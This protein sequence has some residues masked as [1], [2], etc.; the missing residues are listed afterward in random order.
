MDTELLKPKISS[1]TPPKNSY[2]DMN[3]VGVVILGGGQGTRL[4]PLTDSRCKPAI[5]FAGKYRLIDIAISNAIHSAC[6]KIYV[7]TQFLSTSLHK[8]ICR[9]YTGNNIFNDSYVDIL[10][11]EQRPTNHTWYAGTADAVRLNMD[12]LT[13][14]S[15]DYYLILS[16]DQIYSM[17]FTPLVAFAHKTDAD[18]VV[19]SLLVNEEDA[20]RMG[21][22]KINPQ[23]QIQQFVEKPQQKEILDTLKINSTQRKHLSPHSS[24]KTPFLGSMGIYLF[25]R[26]ALIK[27]LE[28][29]SREDFGKHLIPVQIAKGN[30]YAYIHNGF[31]EDIG[32][33]RSFYEANIALTYPEPVF[34]YYNENSPLICAPT[35]LP[36]SRINNT[37]VKHSIICD[38][39]D[40]EAKEITHSIIGPRQIIGAGTIVKHSYLMGNDFYQPPL[41]NR[42]PEKL[43]IGKNCVIKKTIIDKDV[44]IGNDVKLINKDNLTHYDSEHVYIRDGIIIVARGSTLPD[45]YTL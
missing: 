10:T 16:G 12:Y 31:W 33:I 36:G 6:S 45:G 32:T 29:E 4:Y 35:K 44:S 41:T 18:L 20:K 15:V 5:S 24:S 22:M 19:S 28:E 30:T 42:F 14:A 17:D 2:V 26:E 11:A 37:Q 1:K 27:L 21:I 8:H 3:K 25:K 43:H 39:C 23:H 7:I 9:T 34:N 38:G 13:E 40:I